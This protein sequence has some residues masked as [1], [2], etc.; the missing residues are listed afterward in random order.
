MTNA[1]LSALLIFALRIVDVSMMVVR[2]LMVLRGRKGLVWLI[3]FAQAAVF[4]IAIRQVMSDLD[5]WINIAGYAAG[6]ATGNVVGMWIEERLAIGYGHVRVI[7]SRRGATLAEKLR[8]AGFAITQIP[9]RGKDG[10]VDILAISLPRRKI[11]AL[12][13]LVIEIDPNA[14]ITVENVR[15]IH[16]GFWPR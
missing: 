3:G 7:S 10:T 12:K 2:I 8:A 15:P 11:R 4:V 13:E 6:F 16:R 9:G 14:F 1:F 5:N